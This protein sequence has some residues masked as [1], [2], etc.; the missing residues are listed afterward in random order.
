MIDFH[1]RSGGERTKDGKHVR[2]A[3]RRQDSKT[4]DADP[5]KDLCKLVSKGL[6]DI[7]QA[8]NIDIAESLL[9][10]SPCSWLCP[11][12]VFLSFLGCL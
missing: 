5:L 1:K 3:G 7:L 9:L 10:K 8:F 12:S 11:L 6:H 4:W 2:H